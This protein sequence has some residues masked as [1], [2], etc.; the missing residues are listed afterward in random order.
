[1]TGGMGHAM[2]ESRD[3]VVLEL[4]GRGQVVRGGQGHV[5]R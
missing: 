4:E 5:V 2:L 1:M 3:H